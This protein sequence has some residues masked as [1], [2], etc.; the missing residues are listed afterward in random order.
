MMLGGV[1]QEI[2][3]RSDAIALGL[4]VTMSASA[5]FSASSKLA[6]LNVFLLRVVDTFYAP[7]M[8]VAFNAGD[9]QRLWALIRRTG[10][11]SFAGSL[12]VA[13]LL[14]LFPAP[15]L[16][17]F[18]PEYREAVLPL[19]ILAAGTLINAATGSVGYAL[20]MSNN[21]RYF[22]G[23]AA[24]VALVNVTA[25]A[26]FTPAFGIVGAAV[27]TALS[28]AVQNLLMLGTAYRLLNRHG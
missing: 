5:L 27:I 14:I 22:A 4:L 23:I 11:L 28:V 6:L 18:G 15:L 16:G 1:F 21:E 12:P 20:L 25:H 8:A 13:L 10:L 24:L 26:V 17:F 7:K 3:T 2:I 19:Q 9:R